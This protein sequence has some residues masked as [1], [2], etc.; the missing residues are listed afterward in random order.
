MALS[1]EKRLKQLAGQEG[2][3]VIKFTDAAPFQNYAL[4]E[5]SRRDPR[6]ALSDAKS[7]II[8]G[9]YIGG[10]QVPDPQDRSIGRFSR[11]ILSSFY[12]D[13]VTPLTPLISELKSEGYA[14]IPCDGY[15][16]R[17]VLPLKL[18]AVRAGMGWQGKNSLLITRNYGSFMA[19][20][21]IIT[22][23]PLERDAGEKEKD[24]CGKCE[25]CKKA[26]PMGA[27]HEPYRL[28]VDRCLSYLLESQGEL[29]Q[30]VRRKMGN[31]VLE[32]DIC[33]SVCPWNKKQKAKFTKESAL[34]KL[35]LNE[36]FKLSRLVQLSE[37][38]Y[39]QSLG[40]RLTGVD[41]NTFH[42]NVIYA[43]RNAPS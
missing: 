22:N 25:A 28:N 41:Y 5:S 32:C 15:Q 27:L 2:I 1:L 4:E 35:D 24:H 11:L 42:R 21:G 36:F 19:L 12:F 23:A 34:G 10:F 20:G 40:Y 39:R 16:D 30:E 3:D 29:S 37:E 26:C 38:E 6:I 43:M 8:C 7:V 31:M 33:Q 18:A 9:I 17:S 13:V 14:A